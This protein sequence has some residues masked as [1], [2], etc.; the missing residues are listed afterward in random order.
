M[1]HVT[2]AEKS[3]FMGDDA[4]D[5]LLEYARLIASTGGADSVTLRAISG[6]GNAVEASFLL[7]SNTVLMIESTN[8]EMTPPDNTQVTLEMKDRIN[9]IARPVQAQAEE[10]WDTTDYDLPE[11]S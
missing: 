2:F 1:K 4:A 6:D 10:P 11:A 5:T 3:L 7:N 8:A 9:A